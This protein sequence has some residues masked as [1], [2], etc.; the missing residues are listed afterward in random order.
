MAS[1]RIQ[2]MATALAA[3]VMKHAKPVKEEIHPYIARS[4]IPVSF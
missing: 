2:P 3:H 4:A 1:G